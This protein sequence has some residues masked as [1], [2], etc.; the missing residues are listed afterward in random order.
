MTPYYTMEL[1]AG[2][3]LQTR[4]PLAWADACAIARD[5]C[6]VFS[7]IHSRRMIYRDLGPR[8]VRCSERGATKL[9]DF[10]AMA[11]MEASR[12]L[13]G[14]PAFCAPEAV[15]F[16]PLDARTD[17]YSLGAT[18]Y[19]ML[20]GRVPFQARD[21]AQLRPAWRKPPP[22]PSQLVAGIPAALDQLVMD[23]LQLDPALRPANAAEVFE[24]LGAIA[25]LPAHEQLAVPQAYLST[26]SLVGRGAALDRVRDCIGAACSHASGA[27]VLLRGAT[28]SGRSR[29]LAACVLEAKL[30]GATVLRADAAD[31]RGGDFGVARVLGQQLL[32]TA[33][34]PALAAAAPLASV[35]AQVVPELSDR[36]GIGPEPIDPAQLA[37]RALPALQKWLFG[38]SAQRPLVI[39]VDDVHRIDES[40]RGVARI[41][42]AR[43]AGPGAGDPRDERGRRGGEPARRG[44]AEVVGRVEHRDCSGSAR[45]RGNAAA[46]RLGVR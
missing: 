9:I 25:E 26:P 29:L 45:A 43:A 10:G 8:N 13:I 6:S 28:G 11:P 17:L 15:N 19:F 20:V 16:Q 44:F 46:A 33:P 21:F 4:V 32:E 22:L 7:L 18:L 39:A 2:S 24:R 31:A 12:Q 40:S 23:L 35:L 38:V 36:G 41:A 5:L 34:E 30:L 3:D 14:T 37:Q 27:A 1:V 42:R